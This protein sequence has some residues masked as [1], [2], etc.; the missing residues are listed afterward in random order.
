MK[1]QI[2]TYQPLLKFFDTSTEVDQYVADQVI[3]QIREKSNSVLTLPTGSTPK[4]AYQLLIE[5]YQAGNVD[6]SQVTLFE[7]DEYYPI[8]PYDPVSVSYRMRHEFLSFVNLPEKQ[9]YRFNSL[10]KDVTKECERFQK[11][12]EQHGP[13]DLAVLGIGPGLTCH[14]GMNEPGSTLDLDIHAVKLTEDS[15]KATGR[16]SAIDLAKTP[17]IGLTQGIHTLLLSK[18]IILVAKGAEKAAGIKRALMGDIGPEA[19]ASFLRLHPQ[20][21]VILDQAAASQLK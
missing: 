14:I 11:V 4:G 20:V 7:L 3:V 17:A 8:D 6:F 12:F 19:P 15:R 10:A 21:L 9:W 13:A 1:K 5:S 2:Q 18:K 16:K